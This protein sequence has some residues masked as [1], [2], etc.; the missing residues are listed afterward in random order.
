MYKMR[1]SLSLVRRFAV[2]TKNQIFVKSLECLSYTEN[3]GKKMASR[4]Y[5]VKRL[6]NAK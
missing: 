6:D 1:R 2:E 3:M 5:L 4:K